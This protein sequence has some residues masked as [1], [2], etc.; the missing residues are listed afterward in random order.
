[1]ALR[2]KSGTIVGQH[3]QHSWDAFGRHVPADDLQ[4][5]PQKNLGLSNPI[6]IETAETQANQRSYPNAKT[7]RGVAVSSQRSH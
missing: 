6:R 5:E 1:M 4:Q 3:F 2:L 7:F